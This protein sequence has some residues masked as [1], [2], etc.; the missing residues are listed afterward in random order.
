MSDLSP[1]GLLLEPQILLQSV[2]RPGAV[3][4]QVPTV[5]ACRQHS[6]QPPGGCAWLTAHVI[7][8]R[9]YLTPGGGK[10]PL[11][12]GSSTGMLTEA[13]NALSG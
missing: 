5:A 1:G 12:T 6:R 4:S 7:F 11:S 2:Q 9:T 10:A 3:P 13:V 8:M